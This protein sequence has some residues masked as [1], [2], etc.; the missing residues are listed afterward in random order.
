[1]TLYELARAAQV[2]VLYGT[3][4]AKQDRVVV[5]YQQK[6]RSG[7]EAVVTGIRFD[8]RRDCY[9]LDCEFPPEV[10][11]RA[12]AAQA[13]VEAAVVRRG[14]VKKCVFCEVVEIPQLPLVHLPTCPVAKLI[15]PETTD[16]S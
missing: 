8:V 11:Q 9:V 7:G 6:N 1:M 15:M 12:A 16:A 4:R 5:L 10:Y 2:L 3:G 14:S 13:L